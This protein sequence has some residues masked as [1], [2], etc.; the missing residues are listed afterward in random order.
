VAE[1]Q[2]YD[3]IA[4]R[5]RELIDAAPGPNRFYLG[6]LWYCDAKQQ[7]ID[8]VGRTSFDILFLHSWFGYDSNTWTGENIACAARNEVDRGTSVGL[9]PWVA[10]VEG[11]YNTKVYGTLMVATPP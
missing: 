5:F 7:V 4:R 11:K 2:G 1:T 8:I 10:A 9:D 3:A 6:F